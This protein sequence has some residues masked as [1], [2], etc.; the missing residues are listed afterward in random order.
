EA[1]TYHVIAISGGNIAI[2]VGLLIGAFRLA[3]ALGRTAMLAAI[4]LLVGYAMLVGGGASVD[5]AT[6]M[7]VVYPAARALDHQSPALNSLALVVAF[8]VATDP[9]TVADPAFLLTC[10]ATL[11]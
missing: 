1:G 8:L 6:M 5:R 10:G 9:L 3:G 2:L 4:P 7:A 11:A